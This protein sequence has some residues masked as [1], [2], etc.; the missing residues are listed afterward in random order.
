MALNY[1][2]SMIKKLLAE[3]LG[4]FALVFVVMSAVATGSLIT[5]LL[6]GLTLGLMVYFVGHISGTH[7]NPGVTIGAWSI[8]KISLEE[9]AGYIVA[10][11]IGA[12]I[13]MLAINAFLPGASADIASAVAA[14][15]T[16]LVLFAEA[17]G[18]FFFTF[19]IA[20]VIYGK[21]PRNLSGIVVGLSLTLGIIFASVGSAG[22][23][24]PAV[25]M[26]LGAFNVMYI[27]G[28]IIGSILGMQAYK[29]LMLK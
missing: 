20:S 26:G 27:L 23:L 22:I 25:A 10:Q 16:S 11:F 15:N 6:A 9:G 28:P 19:G 1:L 8:G 14:A 7:I 21:T 17:L 24:N 12:G 2:L 5:P 4:T 29:Y 18:M 3:A 13:A